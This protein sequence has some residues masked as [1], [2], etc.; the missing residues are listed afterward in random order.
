MAFVPAA[1][2]LTSPV[3]EDGEAIAHKYS[4]EGENVSPPLSWRGLPEGTASLAL[5]CHDPD[6]PLVKPGSYGFTHWLLYN[7]PWTLDGVEEATGKGTA[8]SNDYGKVGYGGPMPPV[9]HGVH[10]YYFWLV[11]LDKELRLPPGLTLEQFLAEVEPHILGMNRLRATY[12]R[13]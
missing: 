11:A 7:L 13:D 3:F 12:R 4:A 6:A 9:G 8:G 5:F 10:H 1:I 2:I